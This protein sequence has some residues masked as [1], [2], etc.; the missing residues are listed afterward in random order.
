MVHKRLR[1]MMSEYLRNR[2]DVKHIKVISDLLYTPM[3]HRESYKLKRFQSARRIQC[4][5]RKYLSRRVLSK[6]RF[7]AILRSRRRA[8]VMIQCMAR[9]VAAAALV[10]LLRI[11][12]KIS[13]FTRSA[14]LIQNRVRILFARRL[15]R[16]LRHKFRHVAARIIQCWYRAKHS[17]WKT[18]KLKELIIRQK[19]FIGALGLQGLVRRKVAR[20]RVYRLRLRRLFLY[21]F[22]SVLRIQCM[23]RR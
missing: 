12:R 7:E 2:P 16:K 1:A 20:Q 15:V 4:F 9:R 3:M 6:R 8:A 18:S 10:K 21:V 17:K 19:R 11:R 22:M 5:F 13:K 23:V 14:L